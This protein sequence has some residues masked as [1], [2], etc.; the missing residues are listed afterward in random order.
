MI[1]S[2]VDIKEAI[3]T[4]LINI[5]PFNEN[6][7]QPA[8]YDLTLGKDFQVMN[9]SMKEDINPKEPVDKHFIPFTLP[10]GATYGLG[11]HEFLLGTCQEKITLGKEIAAR[12]DGRSSYGRIALAVHITAGFVDP[13]YSGTITLEIKNNL[14]KKG[15]ILEPGVR[16]CQMVFETL[17][18]PVNRPYGDK[19][20]GSK[21]QGQTGATLS[22][23]NE[24][25]EWRDK[26]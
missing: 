20:L 8:S 5:E 22:K 17:S 6:N 23:V 24:D 25:A 7:L 15:I 12:V 1:L 14:P 10:D 9:L 2:D 19:R 13:G 3:E 4:G 21:Y 18:T 11:P 16:I 26:D